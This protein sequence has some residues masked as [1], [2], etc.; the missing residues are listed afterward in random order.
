VLPGSTVQPS[1]RFPHHVQFGLAI[2]CE[3]AGIALTEDLCDEMIR[4]P[5][6]LNPVAK[7]CRSS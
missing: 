2:R 1:Q 7:L 5:P 4:N 3:N 6:E